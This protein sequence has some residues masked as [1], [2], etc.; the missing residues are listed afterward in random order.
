[1]IEHLSHSPEET[2]RLAQSFA[3]HLK[4]GDIVC[5]EGN[6]G[7][8]KTTF[9]KGMASG[10]RVKPVEVTSP[11]FVIMNYYK[12]KLPIYHFDFYRL[13]NP[14]ELATVNFDE[15][16][17]GDG[18]SVVEWPQRL[19]AAMPPEFFEIQLDHKG[20][21]ERQLKVSARGESL[22]KRL[23]TIKLK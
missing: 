21:T 15:Y 22:T 20:E 8:G 9:V 6:L 19:G 7:A 12:G 11:T 3:K 18:I 4:A 13:E 5:L 10:L 17:Y 14:K 23:K 1:M 16:F 2:M